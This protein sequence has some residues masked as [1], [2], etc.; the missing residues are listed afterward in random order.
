MK[1]KNAVM[2]GNVFMDIGMVL[3]VGGDRLH[4]YQ[5]IT[6]AELARLFYLFRPD[7]HLRGCHDLVGWGAHWRP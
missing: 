1:R 2:L 7:G 5:P 6:G 3:M 4:H